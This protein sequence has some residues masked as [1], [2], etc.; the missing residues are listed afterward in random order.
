MHF[1]AVKE[2]SKESGFMIYSYFNS[3]FTAVKR[4]TKF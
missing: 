4:D 2:L 1:M 3:G